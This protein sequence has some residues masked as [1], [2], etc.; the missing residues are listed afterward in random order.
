MRLGKP[1]LVTFALLLCVP[2][3]AVEPPASGTS[4]AQDAEDASATPTLKVYT[5]ETIV[6]VSVTDA[7]GNAVRGLRKSDFI[8]EENGKPQAI[9]SF[10][11]FDEDPPPPPEPAPELAPNE[12][13]NAR[14]LPETGPVNIL[15][16]DTLNAGPAEVVRE[17]AGTLD[18]IRRMP[19]GTQLAIF[20]LS[21]S[22]LHLLQGFTC[23]P[24]LLHRAVQTQMFDFAS[25]VE[26]WTRDW[27]SVDALDQIAAYVSRIK[28]RKNLLWF[29]PGM[30]ILLVRDG[31][32]SWS[33]PD[34]G[35]GW[36]PPDMGVV[37]RLMDTFE[38]FTAEQI[39]IY[40]VDPRGVGGLSMGTMKAEAVADDLGG[41]AFYNT[42]DLGGAIA[43]AIEHGSH[44]YTLSYFPPR[45]KDD[46]HFHS[47]KIKVAEPGVHLVYRKGYNAEL[48]QLHLPTSG[49]PLL[50]ASHEA[51]LPNATQLLFDVQVEPVIRSGNPVGAAVQGPLA[52]KYRNA[53]LSRFDLLYTLELSQ[54]AFDEGPNGTHNGSLEFEISA[55]NNSR[56][57]V[58]TLKQT[59][60]L[61][62]ASD[63]DPE[64]VDQPFQFSQHLDLPPGSIYLH[65]G[66]LD[67]ISNKVGTLEIPLTIPRR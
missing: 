20:W 8:V 41:V 42:N 59:A 18:Y 51:K 4:S 21:A 52:H 25:N 35:G 9:H 19:K 58:T 62:L 23:E 60:K 37:Y 12:F 36:T 5:R 15:L 26:K 28:G 2:G 49:A 48:P 31:G 16:L 64:H 38:L 30:P 47:I 29:T 54:V 55:Y 14:P 67:R 6:D 45:Q 61:P 17:Q 34:V 66:V 27:Y 39:A 50:K 13:T 43:K 46:G 32:Y 1:A 44:F 7:N 11:E 10:V 53:R 63:L 3:F 40:P 57:L 65:V 33:D 24:T 22:G 56:K